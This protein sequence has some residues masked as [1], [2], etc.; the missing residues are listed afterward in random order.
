MLKFRQ[1]FTFLQFSDPVLPTVEVE[2]EKSKTST[3]IAD[4][5]DEDDEDFEIIEPEQESPVDNFD[6]GILAQ[7]I[8]HLAFLSRCDF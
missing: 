7:T 5:V 4:K 3:T 1:I 2:A 8:F 6:K